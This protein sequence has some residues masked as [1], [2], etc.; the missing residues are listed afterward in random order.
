MASPQYSSGTPTTATW[1]TSRWVDRAS[2]TSRELTFSPPVMI[3]SLLRSRTT[4]LFASSIR[5]T[6]PV[7]SQPPSV[8]GR[9]YADM[10]REQQAQLVEDYWAVTNGGTAE[11]GGTKETLEPYM[12][13]QKARKY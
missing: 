3:T 1:S 5:P 7:F 2:S 9:H 4:S 11:K 8:T 12:V 10:N 13:E 6:S